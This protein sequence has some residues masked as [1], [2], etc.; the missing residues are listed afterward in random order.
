M[1]SGHGAVRKM[2]VPGQKYMTKLS[3]ET[4]AEEYESLRPIPILSN[5]EAPAIG[6]KTS[7]QAITF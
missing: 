6:K 2:F 7:K 4:H 3:A 5:V 1:R